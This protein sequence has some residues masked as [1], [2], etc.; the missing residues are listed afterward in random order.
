M[1]DERTRMPVELKERW[2]TALRSDQYKQGTGSLEYHDRTGQAYNCCLGVLC[3]LEG[4]PGTFRPVQEGDRDTDFIVEG[5][6]NLGLQPKW[7]SEAKVPGRVAF[8]F[9]EGHGNS[10]TGMPDSAW[11][12]ERGV[13]DVASGTL[14]S[15]NDDGKPFEAIADFI[16]ERL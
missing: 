14:A 2:V 11:L 3:R 6:Q 7:A 12:H 15:M 10:W 13:D 8:R 1:T 9:A 16:E 4:V 5:I